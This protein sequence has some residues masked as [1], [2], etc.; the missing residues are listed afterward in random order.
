VIKQK[1]TMLNPNISGGWGVKSGTIYMAFSYTLTT[2]FAFGF[3]MVA[4]RLLPQ[5]EYGLV[6]ILYSTVVFLTLFLGQTFELSLSKFVSEYDAK[7]WNYSSLIKY[8]ISLQTIAMVGFIAIAMLLRPFIIGRLFPEAPYYFWILVACGVF[9]G[10]ESGL[11]GVMRG[12]REFGYFGSLAISINL[13]RLTLL[14]ILVGVMKTGLIGAGFSILFASILNIILSSTWYWRNKDKFKEG[15]NPYFIS[16]IQMLR[17][18]VPTMLMFGC[19]AYFYNTGP[20]FIKLLG[21][22]S[23]NE[24]AGF[25]LIAVM[26]SRLPL[27]LSEALS[28]NLLPNMSRLCAK[29]DWRSITY[30]IRKSHHLFIPFSLIS[31]IVIYFFGPKIL[32]VFFPGSIYTRLGMALLMTATGIIMMVAAYNQ[33][34]LAMRKLTNVVTSWFIGCLVLTLALFYPSDIL[35]RLEIGYILSSI[36]IW[37]SL[38]WFSNKAIHELQAD[39]KLMFRKE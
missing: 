33:F 38:R 14:V 5:D 31:V 6:S 26:I 1:I 24:L 11:R 27:Q 15:D 21:G 30:Y 19:G 23:G 36:A 28:T 17:F 32:D 7:G 9:Y 35:F 20:V 3:Q 13:L 39:E 2:I 10:F 8:S 4:I 22:T 12:L 25:F 34:L 29:G 37:L 16:K 18:V